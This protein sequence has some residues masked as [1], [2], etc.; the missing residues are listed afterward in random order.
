MG[1]YF[2][3]GGTLARDEWDETDCC[4]AEVSTPP[5]GDGAAAHWRQLE[6]EGNNVLL[7]GALQSIFT[8]SDAVSAFKKYKMERKLK[9]T[10]GHSPVARRC[11]R[12]SIHARRPSACTGTMQHTVAAPS[13]G[14]RD[15]R[16]HPEPPLRACM[17]ARW[18]GDGE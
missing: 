3:L 17:V 7:F 16:V 8:R 1:E 9:P 15:G 13:L 14:P 6:D 2:W 10:A 12:C 18:V 5:S 4:F 11:P